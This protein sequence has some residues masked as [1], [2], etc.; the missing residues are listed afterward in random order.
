MIVFLDGDIVVSGSGDVIDISIRFFD[1]EGRCDVISVRLW[2]S[3]ILY[4]LFV[5]FLRQNEGYQTF[6]FV[7]VSNF[8]SP[9]TGFAI[10]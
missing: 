5:L 9:S 7:E 1:L 4:S 3:A 2:K 6:V 10:S 8:V